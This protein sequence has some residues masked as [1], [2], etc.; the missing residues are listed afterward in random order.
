MKK[1]NF[2]DK[3][4]TQYIQ[5]KFGALNIFDKN[6]FFIETIDKNKLFQVN[7]EVET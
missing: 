6:D 7:S 2:K 3:K 5:N 1:L 4:G